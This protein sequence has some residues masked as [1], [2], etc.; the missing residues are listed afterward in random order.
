MRIIDVDR[1]GQHVAAFTEGRQ[2]RIVVSGN[3]ATPWAALSPL[4][5]ALPRYRLFALNAQPGVP[6]REGVVLETAFVGP[7][8]RRSPRLRYVPAR[9]SLLPR[10]FRTALLPDVVLLHT[11]TPRSGRL[12]LGTEVNIL[13]AAL[14]A[15]REHGKLVAAVLN[16][17]MPWTCGDAEID[18]ADVDLALEVEAPLSIHDPVPPD[19]VAQAIG[20]RVAQRIGDGATL[21]TGIGAVPDATVARLTG[22]RGLKVWTEMFSDGVLELEAAGAL[23]RD[24]PVRASFVFG[25]QRLYDWLDGNP[26]AVLLRTETT[27]SPTQIAAQPAMTSIN[28]AL[29]I[30]LFAQANASR[31]GARIHSGFGGQPDFGAGALQSAGGQALMALRSWHPKA[32]VSTIVALVDEPVTSFQH[33][34]VVTEQGTAELWGHDQ[35]EQAAHL[36]ESAAHPDVREELWEEAEELGLT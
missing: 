32:D 12:S 11:T 20:E 17:R 16:P 23:D 1:L 3:H 10:L 4:D 8:M 21:Q 36:I 2:A 7:G 14:E 29:Q 13:P 34:A 30:D 28:T 5:A 25:S 19:E 18:V 9:L 15:A 24:V 33:T 31:I 6:D 22:R 27:N 26:R 35:K